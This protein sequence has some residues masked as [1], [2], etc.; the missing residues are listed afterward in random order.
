MV[1]ALPETTKLPVIFKSPLT[2]PPD[3]DN[4]E[5]AVV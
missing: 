5:L 2:V 4:L 3:D 1:V